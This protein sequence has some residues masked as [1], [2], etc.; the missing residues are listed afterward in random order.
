[1]Y[2]GVLA[3]RK[4]RSASDEIRESFESAAAASALPDVVP[5]G[6]YIATLKSTKV[7]RNKNGKPRAVLTFVVT[8]GAFAGKRLWMDLYFTADAEVR[9]WK[10]L[11]N[12][13]IESADE[14]M[15]P[16]PKGISCKLR[17][18]VEAGDSGKEW[19]T[20]KEIEVI[21]FQ[22]EQPDPFAPAVDG[23]AA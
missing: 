13:G 9:S 4:P 18:F 23:G 6:D 19:N 7:G 10:T 3:N 21:G 15:K 17:V 11:S 2:E 16:V 12:I 20:I 22:E 1:M 14:L 5:N 8:E